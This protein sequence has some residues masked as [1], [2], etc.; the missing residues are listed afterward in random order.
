[1][2][3]GKSTGETAQEASLEVQLRGDTLE[4]RKSLTLKQVNHF[5]E[6]T[7]KLLKNYS[8][9]N[10]TVDLATVESIDSAGVMALHLL[11]K[12][13]KER[14]IITN[15]QGAS[16][17]ILQK[18]NIFSIDRIQA[19][20][21]KKELGAA[22]FLGEKGYQ[23]FTQSLPN[24]LYLTSDIIYWS[25][26][27]LFI[28]KNHRKGEFIN[29]A[30]SIGVNAVPIVSVL[31]FI[32]GLVLALQSAEQLRSFGAN[33]YIADL[34]VIAMM[35]EMGPLITAI[36]VAGRSGSAIAAEIATMK[37]TSELDAL[38]TMA[39]NPIRFVVVPKM[40]GSVFTMPFLT[41]LA[42]ILGILGGMTVAYYYLDL[43]PEIFFHRMTDSLLL[44]DVIT[45][46]IKSLIFGVLIVLTGSYYGF[47]VKE[48]AEG[49]GKVTTA[50][51]VVSISLVIV[52]DSIM[53]LIF[54]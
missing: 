53:G 29:Q 23:F 35:R 14:K 31:S 40:H 6:E 19:K 27:D 8:F 37:V 49:V 16:E 33:I 5:W 15:L 51:V 3:Q 2:I 34:T 48:G 21:K 43:A 11:L 39:L 44:K 24:F 47:H 17:S 7:D 38:T 12:N 26:T 28:R 46:F 18:I 4:L 42:D 54:Y 45:G 20:K 13:L 1:M 41:V 25:I 9:G 30:V 36:L 32:I 50:A 10:L 52:A 22:E